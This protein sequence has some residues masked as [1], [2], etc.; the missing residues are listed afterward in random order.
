MTIYKKLLK[1]SLHRGNLVELFLLPTSQYL[2][3]VKHIGRHE[4]VFQFITPSYVEASTRYIA[5]RIN[6]QAGFI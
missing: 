2:I 5:T 3:L 6:V 4:V 1:L